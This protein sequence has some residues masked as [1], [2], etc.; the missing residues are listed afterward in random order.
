MI[1]IDP[2]FKKEIK[3][4]RNSIQAHRDIT[5]HLVQELGKRVGLNTPEEHEILW[6]HIYNGSDWNVKYN[7]SLK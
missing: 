3:L 7:K 1:K 4:L 5:D 6:D 2:K